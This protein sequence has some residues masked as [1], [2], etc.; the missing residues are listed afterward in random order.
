MNLN[1]NPRCEDFQIAHDPPL[2]DFLN[3][4]LDEIFGKQKK[5]LADDKPYDIIKWCNANSNGVAAGGD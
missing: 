1:M 5:E 3:A 4:I 2:S